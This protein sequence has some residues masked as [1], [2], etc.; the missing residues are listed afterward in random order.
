MSKELFFIIKIYF[1]EI[2]ILIHLSQKM[3]FLFAVL[4]LPKC[5]K[6]FLVSVLGFF[7]EFEYPY[8]VLYLFSMYLISYLIG[9]DYILSF[10]FFFNVISLLVNSILFF[11]I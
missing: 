9:L 11:A 7:K 5:L 6:I 4:V 3:T 8:I 10:V 2:L 1:P